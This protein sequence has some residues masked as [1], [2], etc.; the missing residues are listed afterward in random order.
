MRTTVIIFIAAFFCFDSHAQFAS[1][2]FEIPEV[3]PKSSIAQRIGVTE[4]TI[5]YSRPA[6]RGRKIWNTFIVPFDGSPYPWR[7][8]ANE[9]T[10]ITFS[11]DLKV[12]GKDISAGTYG[13]HVLPS[14]KGDWTIAI[15]KSSK[16][17]GSFSYKAEDDVLRISAK[18]DSIP[19]QEWLRYD[20]IEAKNT[21]AGSSAKVVLEW[22][23]IRISI[24]IE[25]DTKKYVLDGIRNKLTGLGG[26]SWITWC[27]AAE[28]C[29]TN[30]FNLEE[31]LTWAERSVNSGMNFRNVNVKANILEQLGKSER[32]NQTRQ[33]A[34][35]IA[36]PTELY[37]AG[38]SELR[39]STEKAME[40]FQ[41]NLKKNGEGLWMVTDGL[42]RGYSKMADY[43]KALK[44]AK[45]ALTN[46]PS[47]NSRKFWEGAVKKLEQNKP[48]EEIRIGG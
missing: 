38:R 19:H 27:L 45:L 17:W 37:Q 21:S 32:A 3:S 18:I 5:E 34:M 30:D 35:Q 6:V 2:I 14:G 4:V 1:E 46:A 44:Y 7:A 39:K 16:A 25:E 36:N 42:A 28:Y 13:V 33:L 22:E 47:E 15:S 26:F 23:R 29:S 9:N 24:L 43:K 40:Y 20:F 10:T 41:L 8:G 11:N 48:I 31:A 12:D